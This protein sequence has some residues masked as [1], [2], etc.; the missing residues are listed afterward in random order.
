MFMMIICRVPNVDQLFRSIHSNETATKAINSLAPEI[1]KPI[2]NMQYPKTKVC[3]M[4]LMFRW[5]FR[6][7]CCKSHESYPLVLSHPRQKAT[8][9]NIEDP[10]TIL[11]SINVC[12]QEVFSRYCVPQLPGWGATTLKLRKNRRYLL[13]ILPSNL[14]TSLPTR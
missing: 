7:N 3:R 14:P 2:I 12:L 9:I 8:N 11:L 10:K 13:C 4:L 6:R 5:E 1:I